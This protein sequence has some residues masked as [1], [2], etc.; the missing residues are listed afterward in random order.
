M[1][2]I[3]STRVICKQPG[4]YIGWPTIAK[5]PNGDLLVVFSG[6]RDSHTSRDGKTQM[7]RSMDQGM[8]WDGPVT[9]HDTPLDD[10]DAGL[11]QTRNGTMLSSWFTNRGG[12]AWQGHWTSRS[13]D[14]GCTWEEP[15]R[16]EVTTPHGPIQLGNGRLLF[17]GQRPHE[18]HD[19]NY[20]VGIQSSD[21]DGR[22]W[23]TLGAFSVPDNMPMLTYDECHAVECA[24]GKLVILFRDC[25]GEHHIRQSQSAD[26][27]VTWS[28]PHMTPIQGYPPHVIRLHNDWLLVVY[29]KRWL[30]F[31]EFACISKDEGQTWEVES[32]IQLSSAPNEDLGY[33]AS[34]QLEDNSILTVYYQVD[35]PG[36]KPCLM[37][38]HWEIN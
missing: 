33:P 4:R 36:E 30:P 10:R 15:V 19:N 14:N 16:T 1:A 26:G 6:D 17:V 27:G 25:Y 7:V 23:Q 13:G 29:G 8:T 20:D 28:Q 34:V 37:A 11:I 31:G 3:I 5:T 35:K 22:S 2:T 24:N 38:T 12:G 21:D 32:E 9:I 18:S